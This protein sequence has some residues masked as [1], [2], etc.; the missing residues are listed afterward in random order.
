[1]LVCQEAYFGFRQGGKLGSVD[2]YF[3]RVDVFV[4][5]RMEFKLIQGTRC[6]DSDGHVN[7]SAVLFNVG[8]RQCVGFGFRAVF[9]FVEIF[10]AILRENYQCFIGSK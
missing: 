9:R 1:M 5:R 3:I 4:D 10:G 6:L 2:K 7:K 8:E